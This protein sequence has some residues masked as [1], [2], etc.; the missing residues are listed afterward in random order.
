MKRKLFLISLPL[1]RFPFEESYVI[2]VV[3]RLNS[4]EF[5]FLE[6]WRQFAVYFK[7]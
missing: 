6:Y 7:C 2:N 4:V 1:I 5:I 3:H